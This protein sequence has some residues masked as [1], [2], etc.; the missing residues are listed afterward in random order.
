MPITVQDLIKQAMLGGGSSGSGGGENL[1][2]ATGEYI[3]SEDILTNFSKDETAAKIDTGLGYL[4]SVF[5]FLDTEDSTSTPYYSVIGNCYYHEIDVSLG[6]KGASW[7]RSGAGSSGAK[8]LISRS[9]VTDITVESE[10][11][12]GIMPIS[13]CNASGSYYLRAGVT[14]TWFAIGRASE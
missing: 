4:P 13:A 11:K 12:A 3:P 10:M 1:E 9:N 8:V 7:G 2:I 14:Y 6:Y 5:V